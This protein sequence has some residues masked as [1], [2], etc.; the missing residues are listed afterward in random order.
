MGF[1]SSSPARVLAMPVPGR[2]KVVA[3]RNPRSIC[4]WGGVRGL[5]LRD[6]L[7]PGA[8]LE[9]DSLFGDHAGVRKR[10]VLYR[11]NTPFATLYAIR[12]GTFKTVMLSEDGHE[13]I[14]G[15]HIAGDILGLDGIGYDL[16]ACDAVALEDSEVYA[17]PFARLDDLAR[18][19]PV[20]RRNLYRVVSRS[21][22]NG[23]DM[24]VLL[25]SL[26]AEERLATFLLDIAESFRRSGFSA[27]EFM[28]RMTREEIASYLGL[29]LETVSRSFS[30]LHAEGLIQVQGRAVKVLDSP[31]L[32]RLAKHGGATT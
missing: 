15:Y 24:M 10:E 21:L 7:E 18:R 12:L 31:A 4:D 32:R 23:R 9:L 25:G 3:L 16:H 11:T 6:G 20:L 27:H 13:Q 22:R 26:S 17:L 29:K 1:A 19:E 5:G 8:M 14:I 2:P 30:R 28:L